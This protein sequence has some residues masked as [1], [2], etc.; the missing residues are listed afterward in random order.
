MAGAKLVY[1]DGRLQEAGGIVW[2]D[3]SAWNYGRGD[4]PAKPE[5][6]YLREVDY[7]SGACL[8]VPQATLFLRLGGFD[9]AF[10]PAYYEDADLCFQVRA[11]GRKVYYQP[12]AEVVHFEGVS[13]GTTESGG[14][15]RHQVVNRERFYDKWRSALA[16]H[17]VNGLLP[18]L[19]RDRGAQRRVLFVEACMLTPDQDCGLGTYVEPAAGHARHGLQGH[20]RRRQPRASPAATRASSPRKASRCCTIRTWHPSRPTSRTTGASST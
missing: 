15:K 12:R 13:H 16:A 11:A 18:R 1:P 8:L 7:C 10:A 4:D 5:Y 20:V 9:A 19:E 2:R 14:I 3:G 17:R 6:E